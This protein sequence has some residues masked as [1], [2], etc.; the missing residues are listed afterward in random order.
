MI[1]LNNCKVALSKREIAAYMSSY[2]SA[3]CDL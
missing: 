2:G 1:Y 3:N